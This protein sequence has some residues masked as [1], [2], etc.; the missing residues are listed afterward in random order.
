MET[1]V[2]VILNNIMPKAFTAKDKYFH[3]AKQAGYRAR[4]AFKLE[5]IQRKFH[6]VKKGD[7]VLDVGAAPG[8]FLQVLGGLVG[9]EGRVIGFDLQEIEPL[10]S[11]N[12]ETFV[13]NMLNIEDVKTKLENIGIEK[14]NVIVSDIAPKTTGI[15]DVDQYRS[16]E[17]N[18]AVLELAKELLK[19]GGILVLKIFVG[20]DFQDFQKQL[21]QHFQK[22]NTFKPKSSRDRS[23]E[24]YLVC[25]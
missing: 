14:F 11:K 10:G 5:E 7:I 13:A 22:V 8:S 24:T 20:A 6:I 15:K 4:S 18:E 16:I 17:L 25:R 21:K 3:K 2:H 9:P 19:K 1:S 23:F 12:I